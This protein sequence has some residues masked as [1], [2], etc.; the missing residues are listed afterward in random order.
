MGS[1]VL[2]GGGSWMVPVCLTIAGSDSGGGAGIQA[3]LKAFAA[4]G[5]YG[6]SLC[7]RRGVTFVLNDGVEAALMLGA[8][9]VHLGRA[10]EGASRAQDHGLLLGLSQ[11]PARDLSSDHDSCRRDRRHRGRECGRL[12]RGRRNGGG[13]HSCGP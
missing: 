7:A 13:G 9:G 2:T 1:P 5:C 3:D 6:T 4:T 10:D 11:R 12:H 8:D